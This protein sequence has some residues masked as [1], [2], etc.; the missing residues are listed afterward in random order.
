MAA[1]FQQHESQ[2]KTVTDQARWNDEARDNIGVFRTEYEKCQ[3]IEAANQQRETDQAFGKGKPV[4]APHQIPRRP[5]K[6]HDCRRKQD[7][8]ADI[9]Q[10]PA[11][12]A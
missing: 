7:K 10:C 11:E 5:G 8:R 9:L 1:Q 3:M 2:G 12:I 6:N 4:M